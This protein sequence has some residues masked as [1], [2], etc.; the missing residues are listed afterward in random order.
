MPL[1]GTLATLTKDY[2]AHSTFFGI[3]IFDIEFDLDLVVETIFNCL[4]KMRK[5]IL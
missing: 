4:I 1:I 3:F 5:H 2:C